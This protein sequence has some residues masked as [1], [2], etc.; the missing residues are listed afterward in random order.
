VR[1]GEIVCIGKESNNFEDVDA[2]LIHSAESVYSTYSDGRRDA[3]ER[4]MRP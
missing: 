2:G 1:I 3:W 4:D